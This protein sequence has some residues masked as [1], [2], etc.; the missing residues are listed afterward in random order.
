M[1][2][3]QRFKF[4]KFLALGFILLVLANDIFESRSFLA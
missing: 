1:G 4:A 2:I 3:E